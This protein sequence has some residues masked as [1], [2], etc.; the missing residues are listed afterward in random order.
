LEI[1]PFSA[2]EEDD[3]LGLLTRAQVAKWDISRRIRGERGQTSSEYMVI[4]GVVVVILL[5]IF[6][7]FRTQI[8]DAM[9]TLMGNVNEGAAGTTR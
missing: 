2:E 9:N 8:T 6:G 4:A 3:M 7:V 5:T 1:R